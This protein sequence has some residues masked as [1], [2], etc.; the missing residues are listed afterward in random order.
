MRVILH[1]LTGAMSRQRIAVIGGVAAGPA[2]AAQ[3]KRVDPE[4]DVVL[5]EQGADISYG[6]C[7]MPY[8]VA[9]QIERD[10]TLIV[11]TPEAFERTRHA[12][13]R[14]RHRVLAIHPRRSRLDVQDMATGRVVEE[15]YDKFILA[16]GA[17][18]RVPDVE[19]VEGSNVFPLR[20][21]SDARALKGYLATHAHGHAVV[22]GGGYIGV[23][24]AEAL[25]LR[26]WRVTLLDPNGAP[27]HGM[28][29][30]ALQPHVEETLRRN[31]VIVRRERAVRFE[32]DDDGAVR[33]IR[34]DRGE[35]IGCQLVVL[36]MGIAPNTALAEAAGVTLGATGAIAVDDRMRTNLPS[37]WACGDCIEV[38]RVI[39]GKKIHWPLS[40]V[41]FRT[42]H[43][44]GTNAVRKGY[45]APARFPGV[46]PASAVKVFDLEVAAVGMKVAEARAAGFDAYATRIAHPSR[47]SMYPGA[48]PVHLCL[49][50][51]RRKG[52][53]LGAQFVGVDGA[54]LRANVLVPCLREEWTVDRIRD[55]DLIYAPPFAPSLDP[56][57]VAAH[58][59]EQAR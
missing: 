46:V 17:A 12:E 3:A 39:D 32:Q 34:T 52:R 35:K 49:V 58:K 40:P 15:R 44:A 21:L 59:A 26:E 36:A 11:L 48:E 4:A 24:V 56:L 53:L 23:E 7:E 6:A 43:V 2:A 57:L 20:R 37:V 33:A 51:E 5:F 13:V 9:D 38:E 41:A 50:A 27:L 29:D 28:L 25:R 31:G 16:V 1:H 14:V 22:L 47:A 45:G 42:A 55:L 19:G 8:Y 54:A 30:E 10:D 18:A